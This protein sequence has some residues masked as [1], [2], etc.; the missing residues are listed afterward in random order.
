MFKIKNASICFLIV[1]C[2]MFTAIPKLMTVQG[3]TVSESGYGD[4]NSDGC[5]DP[6]DL[7]V[8]TRYV[9]GWQG[10]DLIV[11]KANSDVNC[12]SQVNSVDVI[13]IARHLANH[14]GYSK[15]PYLSNVEH[16]TL[17]LQT[18]AVL[19]DVST[20]QGEIDWKAVAQSGVK[21]AIIRAGYGNCLYEV[22]SDKTVSVQIDKRVGYNIEKAKE[23]G[24]K[25]G[26]YWYSY[27]DSV[28]DAKK[29]A[30]TC[31]G[32]LNSLGVTPNDLELP[33]AFDIEET[34]RNKSTLKRQNTD[35]VKAFC[36]AIS[37]AGYTPMV[38]SFSNFFKNATYYEEFSDYYIWFAHSTDNDLSAVKLN[39]LDIDIWQYG[40]APVD[41]IKGIVGNVDINRTY[42]DF[43]CNYKL[44][45]HTA[46]V[47]RKTTSVSTTL[48]SQPSTDSNK[49]GTADK[50]VSMK[51]LFV[52]GSW[53][54]VYADN[55][56]QGFVSNSHITG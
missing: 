22:K 24:I 14:S 43:N 48:Y 45:K 10:Y 47:V 37:T 36:N 18:P 1:I 33:V 19:I 23:N 46:T 41:S 51:V 56:C 35:M 8:L 52:Y 4:V 27:A 7:M 5:V 11:N 30:A 29:E 55:G 26:I 16:E 54:Y 28:E 9:A 25:I 15:L 49:V 40:Y 42:W 3:D 17:A 53:S 6:L 2:V 34:S 38:Y 21:Y 32:V 39:G 13:V 44:E 50:G 20:H 12:D 31:L